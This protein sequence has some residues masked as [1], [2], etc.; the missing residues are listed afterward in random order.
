MVLYINCC[1]RSE[2]RT[3]RLARAVLANMG[4]FTELYLPSEDLHPLT[5]EI[6]I[7]RTALL[8]IRKTKL[9]KAEMLDIVDMDAEKILSDVI[10][11]I[12]EMEV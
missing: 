5:E 8:E 6:L 1:V 2:S 7:K 4:K 9:I 3:D 11:N 10:N 12:L